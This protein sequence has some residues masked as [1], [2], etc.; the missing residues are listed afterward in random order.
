[1]LCAETSRVVAAIAWY[2]NLMKSLHLCFPREAEMLEQLLECC[3]GHVSE[4]SWHQSRPSR[5]IL[6]HAGTPDAL[7]FA[8]LLVVCTGTNLEKLAE[9][10]DVFGDLKQDTSR[11][12]R[13]I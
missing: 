6:T 8:S 1:M 3:E 9:S 5:G 10:N 12:Q 7:S 4:H 11:F 13:L 2:K